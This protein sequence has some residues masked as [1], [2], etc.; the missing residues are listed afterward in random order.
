[1]RKDA[2]LLDTLSP[3]ALAIRALAKKSDDISM[4][5]GIEAFA[6]ARTLSVKG[7]LDSRN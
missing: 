3:I 6:A 5:L 7:R 4:R 1:M 2:Q